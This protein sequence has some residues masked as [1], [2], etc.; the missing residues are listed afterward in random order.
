MSTTEITAIKDGASADRVGLA[1]FNK[2]MRSKLSAKR[3]DG[4]GG[5]NRPSGGYYTG[6]SISH[7]RRLL[8]S[9]IKKGDMVDVANFCMMIWNRQHPKGPR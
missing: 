4:K 7:L 8:A 9:H 5:W 6:C 1:R 3:A 2:A